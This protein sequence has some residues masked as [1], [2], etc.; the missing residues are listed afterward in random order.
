[1]LWPTFLALIVAAVILIFNGVEIFAYCCGR[2]RGD[3]IV[4]YQGYFTKFADV[5]Q[6]TLSTIAAGVTMGTSANPASLNNQTCSAGA[7]AKAPSFPQINLDNI[8][9]AQV[10]YVSNTLM[11][12]VYAVF[13]AG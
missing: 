13:N 9:I 4:N 10:N 12:V 3:Q 11:V 5:L 6:N 2:R 7:D 1:M 8:C